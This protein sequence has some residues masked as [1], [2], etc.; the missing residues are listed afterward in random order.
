[1]RKLSS[2]PAAAIIRSSGGVMVR[3]AGDFETGV[4]SQDDE[5]VDVVDARSPAPRRRQAMQ[6]GSE[7]L[8]AADCMQPLS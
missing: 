3:T 6:I 8:P 2:P 1:M 7:D 4:P 5:H